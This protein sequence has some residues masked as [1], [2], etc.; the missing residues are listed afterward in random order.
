MTTRD[1]LLSGTPAWA[2]FVALD[3]TVSGV[4]LRGNTAYLISAHD[5]GARDL[6]ARPLDRA[7]RPGAAQIV[8]R[9][10]DRLILQDLA[11]TRDGLYVI[12]STDGVSRLFFLADAAGTP[13]EIRLPFA[14]NPELLENYTNASGGIRTGLLMEHLDSLAGSIA[15]KHML[16]PDVSSLPTNA[17]FYMV[18]ASVD[19]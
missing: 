5:N 4:V 11:A 13:R 18:T 12:A 19:R 2:P 10:T 7:G 17:G 15:Y 8:M 6:L 1:Q 14:S 16:G 3:D 9:G